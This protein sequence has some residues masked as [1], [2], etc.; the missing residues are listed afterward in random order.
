MTA[1]RTVRGRRRATRI[2]H[3][4]SRTPRLKGQRG[5]SAWLSWATSRDRSY[6]GPAGRRGAD[7]SGAELNP[8]AG[9]ADGADLGAPPRG[10]GPESQVAEALAAHLR[11][12]LPALESARSGRAGP[13]LPGGLPRSHEGAA[14][15]SRRWSACRRV[16]GFPAAGILR[17]VPRRARG[18][19]PIDIH[20]QAGLRVCLDCL[21]RYQDLYRRP[22]LAAAGRRGCRS[23]GRKPASL[24]ALGRDPVDG[25]R[26]G[27]RR[28]GGPR[29]CRRPAATTSR[30]STRTATR[31]G[32]SDRIA[33]HG[34]PEPEGRI[35]AAI[36]A[37]TRD[38]PAGG[39]PGGPRRGPARAP[40]PV[41]P[42]IVG[43]D[44]L[45]VS[46]VADRAWPFT[47]AYLDE[48]RSRMAA[49]SGRSGRTAPAPCADRVGGPG[50]R[51]RE[52]PV[53]AGGRTGSRAAARCEA[54]VPRDQSRRWPGWM[55]P[56]TASSRR[57]GRRA[58]TLD[59][60]LALD[61][62]LRALRTQ[63]EP[64]GRAALERLADPAARGLAG[65]AAG[66]LPAGSTGTRYS[67]RSLPGNPAAGT[68]PG[69]RMRC[70]WPGGGGEVRDHLPHPVPHRLRPRE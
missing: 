69:S 1:E 40:C 4:I 48:F 30:P 26:A 14:G 68:S 56:A 20:E 49:I 9:Q 59:D 33:D 51:A 54:A 57:P 62:A 5:A 17:G 38:V 70:R 28:P 8:E 12:V 32:R 46:V 31:S 37:A 25:H 35:S 29:R 44:D 6:T 66:A 60:L 61:G 67:S 19:R 2:Q 53:P 36:S 50:V 55:S 13:T 10:R 23:T 22:G 47:H 52:V 15:R 24:E 58:W 18:G 64:S 39:H 34:D 7:G 16:S 27:L 3:Y 43:G 45:L 63:V 11:S 42:H 21:A 41:I 65:P